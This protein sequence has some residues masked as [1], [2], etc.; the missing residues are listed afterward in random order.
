MNTSKT[1]RTAVLIAGNNI[2]Y[3][4][5]IA[6]PIRFNSLKQND[7]LKVVVLKHIDTNIKIVAVIPINSRIIIISPIFFIIIPKIYVKVK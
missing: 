2:P 3:T 1:L 6:D 5:N 7:D 4:I